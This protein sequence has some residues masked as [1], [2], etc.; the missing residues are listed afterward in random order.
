[1]PTLSSKFYRYL[2]AGKTLECGK[3]DM[4]R[5][6]KEEEKE[7]QAV[8]QFCESILSVA[9][10]QCT[11]EEWE[12]VEADIMAAEAK[13]AALKMELDK[14][15]HM[16]R[17]ERGDNNEEENQLGRETQSEDDELRQSEANSSFSVDD[18]KDVE[19]DLKGDE[20]QGGL[21][22]ATG[23]II[24]KIHVQKI[25]DN[26]LK[27]AVGYQN[28]VQ[29]SKLDML[30]EKQTDNDV[31]KEERKHNKEERRKEKKAK[32]EESIVKN[33]F[34]AIDNRTIRYSK[35]VKI[36]WE[37]ELKRREKM[38]KIER[39][40]ITKLEKEMKRKERRKTKGEM[41]KNIKYTDADKEG[42]KEKKKS[43]TK[44][45]SKKKEEKKAHNDEEIK[46]KDDKEIK[47]EVID[48]KKK[49][50]QKGIIDN[51]QVDVNKAGNKNTIRSNIRAFLGSLSCI[52]GPKQDV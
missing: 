15:Q 44:K 5:S 24:T 38:A 26:P 23:H 30:L 29:N 35:D 14:L 16:N 40:Q 18:W 2:S 49:E 3:L 11:L 47:M 43:E 36:Q 4:E 51:D 39:K 8:S 32:E 10:F 31:K 19:D 9:V 6:A 46:K 42:Q 21:M 13:E 27:Y 50:T 25:A 37:K 41:K 34:K 28:P 52:K 12:V 33:H 17:F 45:E 7:Q 22:K 1:M 20:N 48:N